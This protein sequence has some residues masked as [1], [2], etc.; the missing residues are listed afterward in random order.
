MFN[1]PHVIDL[2]ISAVEDVIL[3]LLWE[4]L[5]LNCFISFFFFLV[6]NLF[7]VIWDQ[8]QSGMRGRE[9]LQKCAILHLLLLFS[10]LD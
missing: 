3:S 2:L 10:N 5:E 8:I 7:L 4:F 1:S 6:L 9:K